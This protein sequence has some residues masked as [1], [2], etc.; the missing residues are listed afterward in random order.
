MQS[1]MIANDGIKISLASRDANS[2]PAGS[3]LNLPGPGEAIRGIHGD[4]RAAAVL[5]LPS[6]AGAG[7]AD[8][9]L[10]TFPFA[11]DC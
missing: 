7:P 11:L 2:W 5:Q 6:R 3:E 10:K 9:F 4:R 1:L 8:S